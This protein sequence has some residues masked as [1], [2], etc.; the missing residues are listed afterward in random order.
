MSEPI[1]IAE[2]ATR[3]GAP[4]EGEGDLVVRRA[5]EPQEA[6]AGDLALA[7]DPKFAPALEKGAA[8]AAVLWADADWRAFGLRAA[9]LVRRGRLA[10]AGVTASFDPGLGLAEG[11]HPTAVIDGTAEIGPGAA[12]G[13]FVVV[14]ARARIGAGARIGSHVVI[15]ADVSLGPDALL[16][17]GVKIGGRT[18]VGARFIAHPGVVVGGDGFSFVTAEKSHVEEAR[19]SLGADVAAEGQSWLRIASLGGVEIGDDVEI[20]ANATVDQGTIRPTRVGDGTKIDN[21]VQIGHNVVVG[22]HCLLCGQSGVAGS[23]VIGD[24]V[25]MGGQAGVA[26]NL[27]IGSGAII[28]AGS[29]ILSNVAAGR[30]MMGYPAVAMQT[31][32]EMY[33]ALRR[34]PRLLSKLRGEG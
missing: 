26:D 11:I 14:G 13:A 6:G 10:M 20:G 32:V 1:T 3:L 22:R 24:Y 8:E 31:H 21:L 29:G 30:A 17:P 4:Y 5:C 23:T 16:H 34:L 18:V 9:I 19:E 33:K 27:V 28:G 7:M 2:L 12:I 15:G 25:V